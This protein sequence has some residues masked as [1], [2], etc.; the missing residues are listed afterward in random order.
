MADGLQLLIDAI[1]NAV[2]AEPITTAYHNSVRAALVAIAGQLGTGLPIDPGVV[3]LAPTFLEHGGGPNWETRS[4][5]ASVTGN[6][7]EGWLA[8]PLP[9]GARIDGMIVKG[10]RSGSVGV[11]QVAL[12]RASFD[13]ENA[14]PLIR[15]D[16]R[17]APDPFEVQGVG[18]TFLPESRAVDNNLH[19]YFLTASVIEKTEDATV[20]IH[21]I[22]VKYTRGG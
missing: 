7:A 17:T 15:A 22:Q 9:D 4:V 1:P 20:Q 6:A 18:T 19:T 16:L 13:L 11:F 5:F 2:A 21:S 10:R 14:I 8:V 3:T 12:Q